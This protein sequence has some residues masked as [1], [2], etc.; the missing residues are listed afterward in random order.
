MNKHR[1]Y[2]HNGTEFD[3]CQDDECRWVVKPVEPIQGALHESVTIHP[4]FGDTGFVADIAGGGGKAT[5]TLDEAMTKA[6]QLLL[7]VPGE[8]DERCE[9]MAKWMDAG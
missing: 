3:V 4:R 1:T 2:K 5:R 8:K 7:Y 6:A 9:E